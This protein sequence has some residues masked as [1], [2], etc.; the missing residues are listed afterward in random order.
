MKD[1]DQRGDTS[2]EY[3]ETLFQIADIFTKALDAV[4]FMKFRNMLVVSAST[5]NLVAK[6]NKESEEK[7]SDG[8]AEKKQRK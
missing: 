6:K 1:E 5:L 2:K 8:L 7:K 3:I 4:T